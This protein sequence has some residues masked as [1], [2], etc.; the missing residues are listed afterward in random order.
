VVSWTGD[1]FKPGATLP[2]G[3]IILKISDE[4]VIVKDAVD[5]RIFL[6][7]HIRSTHGEPIPDFIE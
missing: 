4:G 5:N 3:W 6:V 7:N 2:G 1:R